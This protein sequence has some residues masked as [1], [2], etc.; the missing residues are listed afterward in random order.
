M[1]K[2]LIEVQGFE[3]LQKLII[4]LKDDKDK[5][6][7]LQAILRQVAKP[8]LAAAKSLVPVQRS[9]SNL[10][11]KRTIVGGSLKQSLGFIT[12]KGE[13]PTIYVGARVFKGNKY[14]HSGRNTFGDGWYAHM[15]D[16]GHDIYH[17]SRFRDYRKSS[18]KGERVYTRTGGRNQSVLK[19]LSSKYDKGT[20]Q[21]RVEGRFFMEQAYKSTNAMVT[22]ES[23]SAVAKYFQRRI[24]KLSK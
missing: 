13:N 9:Y 5:K 17:N 19:R 4:N 6:R 7:E 23:E 15:V 3:E 21:G 14:K 16:Q 18:I 24:D 2:P 10:K 1:N 22:S 11:S 8:T 12:G 20:I